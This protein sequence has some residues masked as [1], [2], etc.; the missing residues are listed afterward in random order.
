MRGRRERR[1]WRALLKGK[2]GEGTSGV[3]IRICRNL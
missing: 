1:G 3:V 2:M